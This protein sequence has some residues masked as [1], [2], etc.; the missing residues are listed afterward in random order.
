MF[1][2]KNKSTSKSNDWK[3]KLCMGKQISKKKKKK[4]ACPRNGQAL[5]SSNL[6]L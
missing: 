4:K 6:K 5:C 1:L 2:K 3:E